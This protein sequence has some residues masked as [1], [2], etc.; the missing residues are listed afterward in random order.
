[1]IWF[2]ADFVLQYAAMPGIYSCAAQEETWMTLFGQGE[3]LANHVEQAD[4]VD[5]VVRS[6]V[7]SL[8]GF[9]RVGRG[10]AF[11]AGG[12]GSAGNENVDFADRLDD[13]GHAWEVR[14]RGGVGLDFGVWVC[15]LERCFRFG[16]D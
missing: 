2:A 11:E 14:L 8:D 3:E 12:V 1:M 6:E 10:P 9:G 16:E 15:F 5:G 13:F 7:L 4:D